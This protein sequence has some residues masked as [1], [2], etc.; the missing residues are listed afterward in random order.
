VSEKD[1]KRWERVEKEYD[2]CRF[3]EKLFDCDSVD[4]DTMEHPEGEILLI[5]RVKEC[6]SSKQ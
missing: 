6:P 1:I 5:R 3:C 2:E 4:T